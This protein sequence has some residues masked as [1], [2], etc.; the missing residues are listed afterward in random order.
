MVAARSAIPDALALAYANA[1]AD[2]YEDAVRMHRRSLYMEEA[3]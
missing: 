3:Y 1:Y 2:A